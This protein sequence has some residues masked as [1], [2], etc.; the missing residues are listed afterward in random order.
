MNFSIIPMSADHWPVVCEI[1]REGIA[2]GNATFATEPPA[3]E[4]WDRSHRKDCRLVAVDT[5]PRAGNEAA[6][7][8]GGTSV[9]GWAALSSY[10]ARR[11]YAGVAEVSV[12][13]TASARGRGVG[14]LLLKALIEESEGHGIWTLQAGVFPENVASV[15][16][17]KSCG[18]RE[19]G[20]RQRM[21]KMGER[22]RD[23]VLLE[24]RSMA[25]C[26]Q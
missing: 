1:Y 7:S 24:R 10:S 25:T 14:R 26:F 4:E 18:F 2:T 16:L 20:T 19:V 9:V 3:W 15:G 8:P 22:W 17:H 11:V 13:V 5:Q 12:Y 6:I 23:V 21:G